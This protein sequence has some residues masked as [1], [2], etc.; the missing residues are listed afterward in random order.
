MEGKIVL[1]LVFSTL[2]FFT[3]M[4]ATNSDI[5]ATVLLLG[6][7]ML[8][9]IDRLVL[10]SLI[11][12]KR[13]HP[14][15][16][17]VQRWTLLAFLLLLTVGIFFGKVLAGDTFIPLPFGYFIQLSLSYSVCLISGIYQFRQTPQFLETSID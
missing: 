3:L 8:M 1:N 7:F 14:T 2:G 6:G 4:T 15:Q 10:L 9:A 13:V 17:K 12:L 5:I 16:V 11:Q